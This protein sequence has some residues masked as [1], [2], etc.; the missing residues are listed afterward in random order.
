MLP[1]DDR[2]TIADRCPGVLRPHRAEDG[3][4]LRLRIPGGRTIGPVLAGVARL[5]QRY[6]NGEVQLTTRA[7]LQI[8]GLPEPVPSALVE[9]LASLGLLPSPTHDRVRNIVASPLTGLAG[10]R[11]D[12]RGMIEELDRALCAEP[13]LGD[14]SGRFLFA[15]DDGR[16]DVSELPFNL[17]YVADSAAGGQVLDGSRHRTAVAAADAVPTLIRR[18]HALFATSTVGAGDPDPRRTGLATTG[19]GGGRRVGPGSPGSADSRNRQ[20]LCVGWRA[21]V[22]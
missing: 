19:G 1:Y 12:L 20:P 4:V 2:V 8:R 17:G 7:S 9:G 15:L 18:A 10:G 22:R 3:A 14:L 21:T 6:G 16:G 5:S 11:A 13:E